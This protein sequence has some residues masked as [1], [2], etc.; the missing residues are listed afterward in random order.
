VIAALH[1]L[2]VKVTVGERHA[3]VGTGVMQRKWAALTIASN[4]Q[5]GLEQHGFLQLAAADLVAGQGAIPESVKHLGVGGFAL[6]QGDV[7]H[8]G[9]DM[10]TEAAY[11]SG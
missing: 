6:R 8:D 7:V 10:V 5:R 1:L 9:M 2:A 11:Y 4:R 3:A